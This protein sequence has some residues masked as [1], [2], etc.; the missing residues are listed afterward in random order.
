MKMRF[1][2]FL[3]IC[4]AS[5]FTFSAASAAEYGTTPTPPTGLIVKGSVTNVDGYCT[6]RLQWGFSGSNG[7]TSFDGVSVNGSDVY[8]AFWPLA[9]DEPYQALSLNRNY[10]LFVDYEVA[11]GKYSY[12][13]VMHMNYKY[14]SDNGI[15]KVDVPFD[16]D[17]YV[18]DPIEVGNA[19]ADL[20]TYDIKEVY[21]L[22]IG[23]ENA[24]NSVPAGKYIPTQSGTSPTLPL[25]DHIDF[26]RCGYHVSKSSND[27]RN[28]WYFYDNG[29]GAWVSEND[30]YYTVIKAQQ[31][32]S[33]RTTGIM[34]RIGDDVESLTNAGLYSK[35]FTVSNMTTWGSSNYGPM[36]YFVV[37]Q[38]QN[39]FARF[40]KLA[41]SGSG[42]TYYRREDAASMEYMLYP[43]NRYAVLHNSYNGEA[44]PNP[45][46]ESGFTAAKA[47]DRSGLL[48]IRDLASRSVT[49]VNPGIAIGSNTFA[50]TPSSQNQIGR[51]DMLSYRGYD[52]LNNDGVKNANRTFD[53]GFTET[54]FSPGRTPFLY[55]VK[56]DN[57]ANPK[58]SWFRKPGDESI[59]GVE[60]F[61]MFVDGEGN[62]NRYIHLLRGNEWRYYELDPAYADA[63]GDLTD[64]L[65]K[66]ETLNYLSSAGAYSQSGGATLYVKGAIAGK[67]LAGQNT[68]Q[69]N[70]LF[71]LTPIS[72]KSRSTGSFQ[73]NRA[74]ATVD[75]P[76]AKDFN[77]LNLTP[78]KIFQ[79]REE[80]GDGMA[81]NANNVC[82]FMAKETSKEDGLDH[83]YI[84]QYVPCVRVAKYEIVPRINPASTPIRIEYQKAYENESM[85]EGEAKVDMNGF[86][87][88]IKFDMPDY[89]RDGTGN[90]V[91]KGYD[92]VLTDPDHNKYHYRVGPKYESYTDPVDGVQ[93]IGFFCEIK[94]MNADGTYETNDLVQ[95]IDDKGFP[96]W[97]K[98]AQGKNTDT[99]VRYG[100]FVEVKSIGTDSEGNNI[101]PTV[102]EYVLNYSVPCPMPCLGTYESE[103]SVYLGHKNVAD[104]YIK[105][106]SYKSTTTLSMTGENP[107]PVA[108]CYKLKDYV[109]GTVVGE[110]EDDILPYRVDVSFTMPEGRG[111][112]YEPV[113]HYNIWVDKTG[114][115]TSYKDPNCEKITLKKYDCL[116]RDAEGNPIPSGEN[117]YLMNPDKRKDT[118]R[119]F[120]LITNNAPTIKIS[121]KAPGQCPRYGYEDREGNIYPREKVD[122][123]PGTYGMRGNNED[124][125]PD[126]GYSTIDNVNEE[127]ATGKTIFSLY[128][129]DPTVPE[130]SGENSLSKDLKGSGL[131]AND[132][133]KN[134]R[135]FVEAVYASKTAYKFSKDGFA[136]VGAPGTTS[137]EEVQAQQLTVSPNPAI[138]DV[139][140]SASYE[141]RDVKFYSGS[142][143]LVK[144]ESFAGDSNEV[145]IS[146]DNLAPGFYYLNVNGTESVKFIKK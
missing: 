49:D 94:Y 18:F 68:V 125:T 121:N 12:K 58:E 11:P 116:Q 120:W 39:I 63:E 108:Q 107:I 36:N 128:F 41:T 138:S 7:E 50:Y 60:N 34:W 87:R 15:T 1:L 106:G 83:I 133:I 98:D 146:V 139:T 48:K 73:L 71:V 95:Q 10:N 126:W 74:T 85:E 27:G 4:V 46:N 124:F 143:A 55:R 84:Y 16:L 101:A 81:F 132:I 78:V 20:V 115:A 105:C 70:D 127:G 122:S 22:R 99:P 141:I 21:N 57:G 53:T 61:S 113:S 25:F 42:F 14:S 32:A 72:L 65:A 5:I 92:I 93:K 29:Y 102:G 17:A 59:S 6:V 56:L 91:V 43:P 86:D 28:Y 119:G 79:Q 45:S 112:V 2:R 90:Y 69:C 111:T 100:E 145:S 3:L 130:P 104:D 62:E 40:G 135:I 114:T 52:A 88:S 75:N 136:S 30:K 13:I 109:D 77:V 103:I 123:I 117:T 97:V 54:L 35:K 33:R 37:D 44:N 47:N 76:T 96:V 23:A 66:A 137:V 8:R 67:G 89:N 31:D 82:F 134:Y 24:A 64:H 129:K 9:G 19:R 80:F 26:V 110:N 51:C 142:G 38:W 140:I 118:E 144:S 131:S